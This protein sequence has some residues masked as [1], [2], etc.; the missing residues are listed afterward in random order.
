MNLFQ[1]ISNNGEQEITVANDTPNNYQLFLRSPIICFKNDLHHQESAI[2]TFGWA[3]TT[4]SVLERDNNGQEGTN[5]NTIQSFSTITPG[6]EKLVATF[7][8]RQK[9]NQNNGMP[10]LSNIPGLKYIF[11]STTDSYAYYRYFVTFETKAISPRPDLACWAGN[12]IDVSS[13]F[14]G[15]GKAK[16]KIAVPSARSKK[17]VVKKQHAIEKVK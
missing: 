4:S 5:T 7:K 14:K 2:M 8:R 17:P 16:C 11:G 9:V 10:F 6:D 1:N 3:M 13:S 15:E 12:I